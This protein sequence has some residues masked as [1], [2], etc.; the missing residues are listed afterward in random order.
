MP[1]FLLPRRFYRRTRA[2][3]FAND[4]FDDFFPNSSSNAYGELFGQNLILHLRPLV[5]SASERFLIKR[6][7]R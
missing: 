2:R 3:L 1:C 7:D 5:V 6:Q 4:L